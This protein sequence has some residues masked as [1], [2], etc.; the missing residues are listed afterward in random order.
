MGVVVGASIINSCNDTAACDK[1]ADDKK[2]INTWAKSAMRKQ[3]DLY[4][5]KYIHMCSI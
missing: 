1:S 3:I 4:I 2:E 5:Y